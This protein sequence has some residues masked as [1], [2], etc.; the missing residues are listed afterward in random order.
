M[1]PTARC[2]GLRGIPVAG[3]LAIVLAGGLA[4]SVSLGLGSIGGEVLQRAGLGIK[5]PSRFLWHL[6]SMLNYRFGAYTG[7]SSGWY[8]ISWDLL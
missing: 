6:R 1:S 2:S 5:A 7:L 3:V 8:W 4:A